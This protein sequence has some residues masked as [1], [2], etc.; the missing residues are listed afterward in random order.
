MI[1]FRYVFESVRFAI[2][3]CKRYTF[4]AYDLMGLISDNFVDRRG[5]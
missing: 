2:R 4:D 1:R 3:N 5:S